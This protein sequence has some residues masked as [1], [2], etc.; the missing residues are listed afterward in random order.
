MSRPLPPLNA[1]RAF[2]VAA[3]HLSF[4]RAGEELCVTAAA[5]GQQIKLLEDALGFPLFHRRPKSLELTDAGKGYLPAIQGAFQQI[6]EA[7]HL[8]HQKRKRPTLKISMPPTF[9]VKW[10]LPRLERLMKA[11]PDFD[12]KVTT[13]AEPIDFA[14]VDFDLAI[15]F[16]KGVYSGFHS[17][18]C[19][20]VEVFP[21]CS[22]ALLEGDHP[23]RTPGDLKHHTLLHDESTY[24]D[25]STNP[26]WATWLR[27]AGVEG[28]D[29][30]RG[31]SF[32]PSHLVINAAID[33][34]GVA[35]V[36]NSWV[37]DDL[38]SGVLVRPFERSL[39][40]EFAYYVI[41]PESRVADTST[42]QFVAWLHHEVA[43][44]S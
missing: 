1:L 40:V 18:Q 6:A 23:L 11:C 5:V 31:P 3:R 25:G 16:G 43:A 22:R 41:Y 21:V 10:F 42:L 30:T 44:D 35:L 27:S 37:T 36:K 15:R 39:P 9:A 7:T 26:D 4:T 24:S 34:R 8:L 28:V 2:E 13:S 12:T 29:A 33:G 14:R 38:A 32:S 17:E 19:L 20:S